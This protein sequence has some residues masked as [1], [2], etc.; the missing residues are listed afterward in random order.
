ME[1]HLSFEETKADSLSQ[2]LVCLS[3]LFNR[4]ATLLLLVVYVITHI[5]NIQTTK[6]THDLPND[7]R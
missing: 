1:H 4:K 6:A 7:S 3:F 2:S 5:T